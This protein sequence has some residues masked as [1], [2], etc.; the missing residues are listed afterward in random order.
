VEVYATCM[1]ALIVRNGK[2]LYVPG[3][4]FTFTIPKAHEVAI[5]QIHVGVPY[6]GVVPQSQVAYVF[7]HHT[8]N[9]LRNLPTDGKRR[10]A[11]FAY[12]ISVSKAYAISMDKGS[13]WEPLYDS[14]E[15]A[16][17]ANKGRDPGMR[18]R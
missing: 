18:L 15:A 7:G 11:F 6:R 14:I 12:D 1:P 3:V 16:E 17:A 9:R 2:Q 5:Y 8:Y 13:S 4:E 10:F